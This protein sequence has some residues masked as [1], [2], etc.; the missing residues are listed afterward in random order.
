MISLFLEALKNG[1][2]G[3]GDD[4]LPT[5][6]I[7]VPARAESSP[8]IRSRIILDLLLLRHRSPFFSRRSKVARPRQRINIPSHPRENLSFQRYPSPLLHDLFAPQAALTWCKMKPRARQ[9][10]CES[11]SSPSPR[12]PPPPPSPLASN[13][14]NETGRDEGALL[15]LLLLLLLCLGGGKKIGARDLIPPGDV[16]NVW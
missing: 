7:I 12:V 14:A 8:R 13:A 6:A 2:G 10:T 16:L 3:G 4:A 1:G 11:C 15:L 5:D 9:K